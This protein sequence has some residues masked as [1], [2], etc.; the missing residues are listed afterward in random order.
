MLNKT[1][2]LIDVV[3]SYHHL[4]N[5]NGQCKKIGQCFTKQRFTKKKKKDSTANLILSTS[6]FG[7]DHLLVLLVGNGAVVLNGQNT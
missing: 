1:N 6:A 3:K 5:K 4:H 7:S 2:Y